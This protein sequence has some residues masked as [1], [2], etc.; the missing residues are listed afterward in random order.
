VS[1]EQLPPVPPPAPQIYAIRTHAELTWQDLMAFFF[2]CLT[3]L[4]IVA[5]CFGHHSWTEAKKQQLK[6]HALGMV[7]FIFGI[8]GSALWTL[9]WLIGA[10]TSVSN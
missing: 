6:P 1:T 10:L 5:L 7:G 3:P 4:S 8:I 9:F 2:G